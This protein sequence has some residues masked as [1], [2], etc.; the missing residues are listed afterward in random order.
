M[1]HHHHHLYEQLTN[2]A[3]TRYRPPE[4]F[5]GSKHYGSEIDIWSAGCIMAELLVR[6][7]GCTTAGGFQGRRGAAPCRAAPGPRCPAN[8][9]TLPVP[10]SP[11]PTTRAQTGKPLFAGRDE[12]DQGHKIF[13]I[14]GQP[15]EATMPGCTSFEK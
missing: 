11:P 3:P 2:H 8:S 14:C 6:P 5:L 1:H 13:A 9:T 12:G 15:N 10:P 4:L 7:A